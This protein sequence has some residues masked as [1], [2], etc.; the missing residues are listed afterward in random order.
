[1]NPPTTLPEALEQIEGLKR[2]LRSADG[3][4]SSLEDSMAELRG[5]M[6]DL[7]GA[8]GSPEA[9]LAFADKWARQRNGFTGHAGA[10]L[11]FATIDHQGRRYTSHG[12]GLLEAI[13]KCEDEFKAGVYCRTSIQLPKSA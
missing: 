4:S 12:R 1:M 8:S 13:S 2:D 7:E 5:E 9:I 6:E 11:C 10:N 3:R